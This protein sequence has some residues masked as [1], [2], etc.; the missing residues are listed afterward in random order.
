MISSVKFKNFRV[1]QDTT[2]PLDRFTLIVGPNGSGKSTALLALQAAK[3][4]SRFIAEQLSTVGSQP[5]QAEVT[6]CWG[7]PDTEVVTKFHWGPTSTQFY[8]FSGPGGVNREQQAR[9]KCE[10]ESMRFYA[11]DPKEIEKPTLI[12]PDVELGSNG[13][14]LAAVLDNLHG[15]E[16]ERFEALNQ[17]L[18]QMMPEF[19]RVLLEATQDGHK[20]FLLRTVERHKIPAD[21]LSQGTLLALAVLTLAYLPNPPS[22]VCL[23]EPDRGIHPRLLREVQDT[24]YRLCYPE[25]FDEQREPVQ[26]IATTHSPYLLDLYR[27]YPE[28]V[29]IANKTEEGTRFERLSEQPYIEEILR[30]AQLGSIWYTGILGGVPAHL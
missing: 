4:P 7:E 9:L 28:Q 20:A 27:D 3:E 30:D 23:E 11:L 2:L 13:S 29:V 26:V 17:A 6:I 5:C 1:L 19:D 16:P 25:N 10:L 8:Q 15:Q 21:S 24:L 12:R 14:Y 18:R 22:V